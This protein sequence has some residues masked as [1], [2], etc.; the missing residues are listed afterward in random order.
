MLRAKQILSNRHE[1][2][3]W[4]ECKNLCRSRTSKAKFLNEEQNIAHSAQNEST[5]VFSYSSFTQKLPTLIH[6]IFHNTRWPNTDNSISR[7][8][9]WQRWATLIHCSACHRLS[10]YL[11][12]SFKE[13]KKLHRGFWNCLDFIFFFL[14]S[15]KVGLKT[16]LKANIFWKLST[17]LQS[18]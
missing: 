10:A 1:L 15:V 7:E 6:N 11:T 5:F 3:E 2:V 16:Y 13:R 12:F 8:V 14:W 4:R 17:M 9:V 18:T